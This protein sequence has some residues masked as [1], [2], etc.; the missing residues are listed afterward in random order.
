MD[1]KI[2]SLNLSGATI[3]G[4][5]R[6]IIMD[7]KFRQFVT[8]DMLP[9]FNDYILRAY[10]THT[11]ET[12]HVRLIIKGNQ[13][14]FVQIE[15]IVSAD[16]EKCQITVVE[17][18]IQKRTEEL[19]KFKAHELEQFDEFMLAKEIRIMELKKEINHLLNALGEKEKFE[20]EE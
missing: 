16:E 6:S 9:Q 8:F 1:G 7:K 5:E 19:L 14:S 18:T 10:E 3:F 17:E 20:I 11:K 12:C 2:Y 4:R 13:S 15:G